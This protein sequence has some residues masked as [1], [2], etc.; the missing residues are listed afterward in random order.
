MDRRYL[1]VF[2]L[3]WTVAACDGKEPSDTGGDTGDTQG[4]SADTADSGDSGDTADSGDSAD[5]GDSGT[6]QSGMV[7]HLGMATADTTSYS[8]TEEWYLI[9]DDGEGDDVCRIRT[10]LTN[11]GQP[12]TDCADCLWAYDLVVS[13]PEIVAESGPGCTVFGYDATNINDLNGTM[14]SYGYNPD[15]Y[16]HAQV[17]ATFDGSEW[18]VVTFAAWDEATGA[19]T[20]DWQ[21]GI[22]DY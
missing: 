7:G 12:R 5:T 1:G 16:G 4:D 19:L 9:A 17:L 22:Q 15:Y 13:A 2:L 8:G 20:Y 10:T 14:V 6:G 3:S 21:D 18:R 11:V